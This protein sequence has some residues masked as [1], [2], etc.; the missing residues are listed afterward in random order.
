I[1]EALAEAE[2]RLITGKE[3]TPFLL[4]KVSEITDGD[5]L[6]SNIALIEN[7]VRLGARTVSAYASLTL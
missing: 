2:K 1:E 5:S 6:K 4:A 3:I 7:N